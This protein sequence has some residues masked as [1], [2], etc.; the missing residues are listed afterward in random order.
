[1]KIALTL[2]L[3]LVSYAHSY[4]QHHPDLLK[5][6]SEEELTEMKA[7]DPQE[8]TILNNALE[9]GTFIGPIPE[10]KAKSITFDGE[11]AI[12][13][14][15]DHNFISLGV[16]LKENKYQYFRIK[17]TDQMVGVLPKSLLH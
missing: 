7:S 13:P 4:G 12:N 10:E 3:F 17:G 5:R 6:Y 9:H 15:A 14:G 1:M 16:K 2:L 8:Y 11:L